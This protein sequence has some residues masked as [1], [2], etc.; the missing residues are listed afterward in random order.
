MFYAC[1]TL[2][3][4][5]GFKFDSAYPADKTYAVVDTVNTPGYFTDNAPKIEKVADIL[6]TPFDALFRMFRVM[7]QII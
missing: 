6:Q 3:G 5:N 7:L 2:E 4:G 1:L